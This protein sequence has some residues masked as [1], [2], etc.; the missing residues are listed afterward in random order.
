M[1]HTLASCQLRSP[2]S[3]HVAPEIASRTE[4]TCDRRKRW[5]PDPAETIDHTTARHSSPRAWRRALTRAVEAGLFPGFN[6]TTAAILDVIQSRMNFDTGH[7]CYAMK[8]VIERTGLKRSTVTKHIA[9]VRR[10]GWLAWAVHGSRRNVLRGLG[11]PGYARTATVYA[12]TIPPEYDALV[13]NVL[14]GTG[15]LARVITITPEARPSLPVETTVDVAVDTSGKAPVENSGGKTTWTPSPWVVSVTSQV[16]VSGGNTSS[17]GQAR[18]AESITP[19]RKKRTKTV[20]GYKITSE[21][22]E[23]ARQ[24]AKTVRPLINWVQGSTHDQL[25]WVL[26]DLVARDW[27]ENKILIWLNKLGHEIG[28]PR[29]RPQFPHRVIAAAL[30][31]SDK[32]AATRAVPADLEHEEHLPVK[33]PNSAWGEATTALRNRLMGVPPEPETG[34]ED[35][36]DEI[37]DSDFGDRMKAVKADPALARVWAQYRGREEAIRRFGSEAARIL[38]LH[39]LGIKVPAATGRT[40]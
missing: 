25:S 6:D 37:D 29:W 19:R 36:A 23:R 1:Q 9:M 7:A 2:H 11:L 17:T 39:G 20:T 22:I 27:S 8:D 26:L 28:A 3:S 30:Q 12:A 14:V 32:E 33:E 18:T 16:H 24:L 38:D 15:Y 31:R 4:Q 35:S 34:Y 21:R 40:A 13:G 10:A 5:L